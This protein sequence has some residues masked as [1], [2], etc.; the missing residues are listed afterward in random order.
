MLVT[1]LANKEDLICITSR[2]NI[3]AILINLAFLASLCTKKLNVLEKLLLVKALV[4]LLRLC[5]KIRVSS[6][7][8]SSIS[9]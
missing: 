8:R 7:R 9:C 5:V 1:V 3:V 2:S 4:V 6:K